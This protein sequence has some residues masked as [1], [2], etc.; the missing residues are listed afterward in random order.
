MILEYDFFLKIAFSVVIL[1][2]V[3]GSING[4]REGNGIIE[5]IVLTISGAAAGIIVSF[6]CIIIV[7]LLVCGV[8]II[9]S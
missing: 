1:G 3:I 9:I 6:G 5:T 7:T 2:I 4:F 8:G